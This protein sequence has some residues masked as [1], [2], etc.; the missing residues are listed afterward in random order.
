[1]KRQYL[2]LALLASTLSLQASDLAFAGMDNQ[3]ACS[4][5]MAQ[6]QCNTCFDGG[7]L[8]E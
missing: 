4:S 7:F 6:Y 2:F 8:Y 1:M 5:D 3:I